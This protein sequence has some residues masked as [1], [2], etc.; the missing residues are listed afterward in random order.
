[1]ALA[2]YIFSA[3]ANIGS[4]ILGMYG[5]QAANRR[6]EQLARDARAHDVRMWRMM[7]DYNT[8]QMQMQRLREAGLNPNL[9]YGSG[10]ANTGNVTAA[11]KSPVAEVQNEMANIANV[12]LLPAISLYQDWQV[13]K[14]QIDNLNAQKEVLE[15]EKQAKL[16]HNYFQEE[17]KPFSR[18]LAESEYMNRFYDYR[19]K[20]LET[21]NLDRDWEIKLHLWRDKINYEKNL[22]NYNLDMKKEQIRSLRL[23]NTLDEMLK[24]Y[25]MTSRDDLW[26]RKL[27]PVVEDWIK[28]LGKSGIV[29]RLRGTSLFK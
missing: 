3:A 17:R 21:L 26:A 18:L 10:S 25:G 2:P 5:Q 13:K 4:G 27:L 6:N 19:K 16:L 1:M 29:N 8:P 24:P 28:S 12:N 23:N 14:A 22:M 15:Q 11:Q 7:A 20:H 9:I